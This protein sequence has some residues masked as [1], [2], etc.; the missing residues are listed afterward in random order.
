M[1]EDLLR[2]ADTNVIQQNIPQASQGQEVA[3]TGHSRGHGEGGR[4][5]TESQGKSHYVANPNYQAQQQALNQQYGM[6]TANP[7]Q[8]IA[9]ASGNIFD[10]TQNRYS[11]NPQSPVINF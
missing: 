4:G 6:G 5:A 8:H 1:D 7:T 3:G 9:E 10:T 11:P 2:H